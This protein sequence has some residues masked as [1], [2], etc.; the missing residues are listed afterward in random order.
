MVQRIAIVRK[1]KCKGGTDCPY[2]C[3]NVCPVNRSGS[4]GDECIAIDEVDKKVKIDEVTCIGCKICEKKCPFDAIDIINLPE[5]WEET[6]IHTYGQNKFKLYNLPLPIFGKVVGIIG[7]NGTGKS[8]AMKILAGLL[9]PNFGETKE[10]TFQEL[11]QRFKGME[12]QLYFQLL[13]EGKI[14]VAFKP[15]SVDLIPKQV[16]GTVREILTKIDE[17]GILEDVA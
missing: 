8:T 7:R 6:P 17:K 15:Q 14:K 12:S 3:I 2:I 10:H 9:K 5:E 13:G 4:R 1:E 11:A 16:Q